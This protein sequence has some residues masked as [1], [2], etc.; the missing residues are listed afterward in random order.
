MY[1]IVY[2]NRMKKDVK[3]MKI[4]LSF[5]LPQLEAMLICL[6]NSIWFLRFYAIFLALL[7]AIWQSSNKPAAV[8][9]LA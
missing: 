1:K 9:S 3:L 5:R 4:F 7:R 8:Y 6:E 2:T